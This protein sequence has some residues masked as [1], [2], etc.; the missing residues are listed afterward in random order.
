MK[1]V[2]EKGRIKELINEERGVLGLSWNDFSKR[3]GASE[4][5]IKT[6]IYDGV[7]MSEEVFEK[8]SLKSK[9]KKYIID[10]KEEN[11]G[12]VKGGKNS[13]GNTKEVNFPKD[14]EELA[15]F[16]GIMLGDGNSN[17]TKGYKVGVY[18]IRIVGDCRFDRKYLL[19]F[20]KPLVE[21]LFH[22][23]VHVHKSKQ[24]NALNLTA[25]GRKLIDFLELKGFKPGD[26][27]RNQLN[28]PDWIKTNK[29]YLRACLRGLYDTDG[30]AYRLTNQNSY[31]IEFTNL[32]MTLLNDVRNSLIFLGVNPSKIMRN[33]DIVITRKSEL[34]KF[35]NDVGFHNFKHLNKVKM[36]NL[37]P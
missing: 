20:V 29:I 32:N 23:A 11:W 25:S 33:K 7:L 36:W 13:V 19:E 31:Q 4:S 10:K 28:I 5:K 37:V 22:V 6:F 26:K 14:S 17:R 18:Q 2:F 1:L 30:T 12:K 8:F 15:E 27:I 3:L 35:L 16:Y 21:K 9:F 24:S 34:R